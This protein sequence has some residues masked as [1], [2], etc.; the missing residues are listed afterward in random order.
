MELVDNL[1]KSKVN[2]NQEFSHYESRSLAW[3][4]TLTLVNKT[5]SKSIRKRKK[6]NRSQISSLRIID[7]KDNSYQKATNRAEKRFNKFINCR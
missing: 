4:D 2:N 6:E 1:E 7:Q 3:L 5:L